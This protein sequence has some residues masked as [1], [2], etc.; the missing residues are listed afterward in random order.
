MTAMSPPRVVLTT[1]DSPSERVPGRHRGLVAAP[2]GATRASA[3]AERFGPD[4]VEHVVGSAQLLSRV[5]ASVLA[6]H[7]AARCGLRL[8][9]QPIGGLE[10]SPSLLDERLA[11]DGHLDAPVGAR[12]ELYPERVLDR[13][14]LLGH[15]LLS[16]EQVARGAREA[17]LPGH[18]HHVRIWRSPKP[19]A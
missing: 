4:V 5:Q 6:A 17:L 18:L 14:D 12:E 16:D 13:R 10:R 15:G 11:R 3:L 8:L 2:S 1:A 7:L 19:W 9:P